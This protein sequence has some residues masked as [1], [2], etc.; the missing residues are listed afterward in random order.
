MDT[1]PAPAADIR[2]QQL[3][4]LRA[5]FR[6]HSRKAC[7]RKSLGSIPYTRWKALL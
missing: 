2:D 1:S 6:R 3:A 4:D 5:A 7:L